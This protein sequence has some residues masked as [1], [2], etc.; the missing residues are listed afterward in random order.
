MPSV[1][2]GLNYLF[3]QLEENS[4]KI[5]VIGPVFKKYFE[6]L[7]GVVNDNLAREYRTPPTREQTEDKMGT[8]LE[9]LLPNNQFRQRYSG[10]AGSATHEKIPIP[11]GG[12]PISGQPLST[13]QPK[14]GV[15]PIT[16]KD[17]LDTA[18]LLN[19]VHMNDRLRAFDHFWNPT[20]ISG[21][22][23]INVE[24]VPNKN[25]NLDFVSDQNINPNPSF[26]T[27]GFSK[28][29]NRQKKKYRVVI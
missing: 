8:T 23:I 20:A 27:T 28:L 19:I 24:I 15:T 9:K 25:E 7:G 10:G 13:I 11:K 29:N 16:K 4:D 18:P 17:I 14:I 26:A 6:W 3:D 1:Q 2:Q 12:Y 21:K 5:P 22:P